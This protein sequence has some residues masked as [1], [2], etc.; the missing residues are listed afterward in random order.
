MK[1]RERKIT[2][3]LTDHEREHLQAQ[4][5]LVAIGTE[6]FLR[7]LIMGTHMTP[8]PQ[9]QWAELVRQVSGIATNVNQIATRVNSGQPATLETLEELQHM[10]GQIWDKL[11]EY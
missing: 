3:R 2:V 1:L 10:V 11:K 8:R 4:S 7:N 6:P 9:K 5:D